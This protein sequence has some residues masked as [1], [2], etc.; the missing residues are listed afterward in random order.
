MAYRLKGGD[1]RM[2]EIMVDKKHV[3]VPDEEVRA[4]MLSKLKSATPAQQKAAGDY[5][6]KRHRENRG[7]Y[8]D[9]MS[10]RI[11]R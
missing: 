7:V 3:G 5:A 1:R 11:G 8:R 4:W 10:G 9:V 2:I 6:V